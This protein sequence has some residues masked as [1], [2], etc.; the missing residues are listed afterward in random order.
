MI[1]HYF[2]MHDRVSLRSMLVLSTLLTVGCGE[3]NYVP[4]AGQLTLDGEALG[5]Y[6]VKFEPEGSG[7]HAWA[8]SQP[9]GRF[10]VQSQ[11]GQRGM[12]AGR[13][14]VLIG[15]FPLEQASDQSPVLPPMPEWLAKYDRNNSQLF[16]EIETTKD[17]LAIE[18]KSSE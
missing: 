4:V 12:L 15:Y 1:A 10:E 17:D 7:P 9:D 18:L 2:S 3:S 5:G 11:G 6:F 8:E 16:V 13:Y 14:R